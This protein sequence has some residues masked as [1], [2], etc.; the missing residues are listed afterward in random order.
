MWAPPPPESRTA[1]PPRPPELEKPPGQGHLAEHGL[2]PGPR[3]DD[4][5]RFVDENVGGDQFQIAS[6][7]AVGTVVVGRDA[8]DASVDYRT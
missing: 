8:N 4:A 5:R 3:G 6:I 2:I 7:D 1:Q